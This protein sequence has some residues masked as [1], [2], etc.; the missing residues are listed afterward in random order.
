M[1]GRLASSRGFRQSSQG[2]A[3]RIVI[4]WAM[5]G[6]ETQLRQYS[7]PS[8]AISS[9]VVSH[10]KMP[11]L[12]DC[13]EWR[14]IQGLSAA[15]EARKAFHVPGETKN[16]S[17]SGETTAYPK[18]VEYELR[19]VFERSESGLDLL[20]EAFG[21]C[22]SRLGRL[23]D[24]L[25]KLVQPRFLVRSDENKRSNQATNLPN[26]AKYPHLSGLLHFLQRQLE[27]NLIATF[28]LACGPNQTLFILPQDV[29]GVK[30]VMN[31]CA[32]WNNTIS[33]Y[34]FS[35]DLMPPFST[36]SCI[37]QSPERHGALWLDTNMRDQA[38]AAFRN[39]FRHMTCE[40][41]HEILLKLTEEPRGVF[42]M[43]K[44]QILLRQCPAVDQ[45]AEAL[46]ENENIE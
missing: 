11:N 14:L 37:P 45:W 39:I 13:P 23:C 22:R 33:Q 17:T 24:I 8:T 12:N 16:G 21:K 20:D 26:K 31:V 10:H 36:Q 2:V 7:V 43:P 25:D 6:N 41:E 40:D 18:L 9:I 30:E 46:V 5:R 38:I 29:K 15:L 4:G 27:K 32:E 44:L 3:L 28:D 34:V 42:L 19:R 1:R 35:E